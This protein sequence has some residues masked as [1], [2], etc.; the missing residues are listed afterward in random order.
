[1]AHT[2]YLHL[3]LGSHTTNFSSLRGTAAFTLQEKRVPCQCLFGNWQC[4]R[5]RL[6]IEGIVLCAYPCSYHSHDTTLVL[7]ST[8]LPV[9]Q[10][11][12]T[13]GIRGHS[14]SACCSLFIPLLLWT[15][16]LEMVSSSGSQLRS[17]C[18]KLSFGFYCSGA[19]V[20]IDANEA[21]VEWCN[22]GDS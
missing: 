11:G 2:Q 21:A 1:M 8:A 17:I 9:S 22:G 7:W 13:R 19:G 5:S 10:Q 12:L 3:K 4:S 15:T 18:W 14:A 20:Q 6:P 16:Q